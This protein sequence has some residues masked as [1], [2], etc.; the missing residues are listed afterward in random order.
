[1]GDAVTSGTLLRYRRSSSNINRNETISLDGAC[2][3]VGGP[4][5][6]EQANGSLLDIS[7]R[8]MMLHVGEEEDGD[9]RPDLD[10]HLIVSPAGSGK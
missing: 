3:S 6:Q 2:S 7:I 9:P 1:M 5:P 10:D 4:W 8:P